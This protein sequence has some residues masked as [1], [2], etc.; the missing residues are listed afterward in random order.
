MKKFPLYLMMMVF[1][2]SI[3]PQTSF[4]S[5]KNAP[6]KTAKTA[7]TAEI[8]AEVKV[9]LNRLEEIKA[10]DKSEMKASEKKELRKEVR[11]IKAQ[12]KASNNGVY[13]S[14]GAIII[15]I[16]LLILIL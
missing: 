6:A 15:V 11:T 7:K 1:S 3:F 2:L 8:P 9:M 4:A 13:L 16:L 14:V 12:L 10:M 5:E